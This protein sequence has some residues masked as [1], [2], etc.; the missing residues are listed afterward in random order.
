MLDAAGA[1][2][3]G[4]HIDS[5]RN[6]SDSRRPIDTVGII[7]TILKT[8]ENRGFAKVGGDSSRNRLRIDGFDTQQHNGSAADG[9]YICV[10][11]ETYE[12]VEIVAF[13]EQTIMPDSFNVTGTP[14]KSDANT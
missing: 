8:D 6:S 2:H 7:H 9:T 5:C 12:F 13:E 3:C 4:C 10:G 1:D 14:D 11:V